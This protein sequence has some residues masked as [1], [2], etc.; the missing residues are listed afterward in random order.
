MKIM[1]KSSVE[2]SFFT[3][4]DIKNREVG[5]RILSTLYTRG[6][7]FA[8]EFVDFG[9]GWHPISS[10]N[11]DE[12]MS[13]WM[14][15]NNLLFGRKSKYQSQ[16]ALLLSGSTK[17]ANPITLWVE[18]GF[19]SL[20]DNILEFIAI[21][22]QIYEATHPDFGFIHKTE[23]KIKMSTFQHPKFGN[24][25]L[26]INIE[27]GIPGIYWANFYGPKIIKRIGENRLRSANWSRF[28]ILSDDGFLAF[29]G[30]SPVRDSPSRDFQRQ[31]ELEIGENYFYN[32]F[33]N[34]L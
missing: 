11:N 6:K 1:N 31:L 20:P 23:D 12:I 16:I 34:D 32:V 33:N 13:I 8:P 15:S 10:F 21:G 3:K 22:K 4:T 28:E 26:P 2:I 7:E 18:D 17:R 27:K 14:N 5:E 24:T 19:F 30:S 29:T 25:V 9:N